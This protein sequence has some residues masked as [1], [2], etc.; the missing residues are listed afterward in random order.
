VRG[1]EGLQLR[2]ALKRTE[3]DSGVE[4]QP[5]VVVSRMGLVGPSASTI[6]LSPLF[7]GSTIRQTVGHEGID[8]DAFLGRPLG[9]RHSSKFMKGGGVVTQRPH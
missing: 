4:A 6:G 8:E 5:W 7:G 3:G 2:L 1:L 9:G